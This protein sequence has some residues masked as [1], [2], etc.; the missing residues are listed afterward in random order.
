MHLLEN[1]QLSSYCKHV[2]LSWGRIHRMELEP[3]LHIGNVVHG[4]YVHSLPEQCHLAAAHLKL[5]ARVSL[6]GLPI[7]PYTCASSCIDLTLLSSFFLFFPH[8]ESMFSLAGCILFDMVHNKKPVSVCSISLSQHGKAVSIR[9]ES[10]HHEV[11]NRLPSN[12][13]CKLCRTR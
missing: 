1:T 12:G 13:T 2:T 7:N 11:R 5:L 9:A 6:Q 4:R 8:G 10:Y 3:N